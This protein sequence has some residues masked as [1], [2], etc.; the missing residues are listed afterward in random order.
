RPRPAV[1]RIRRP[2]NRAT[3]RQARAGA[4]APG[5]RSCPRRSRTLARQTGMARVL[6][7]SPT[8]LFERLVLAS[9]QHGGRDLELENLVGAFVEA[10]AGAV[11]RVRAGTIERGPAATA[12]DLH[13]PI[14]GVPGGAGS[15]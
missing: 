14:G 7:I 3:L 15:E 12:E 13:S 6:T 4:T 5:Q 8:G 1:A 10:A 2:R 11:W 9:A